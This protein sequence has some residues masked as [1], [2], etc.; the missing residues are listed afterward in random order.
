MI[1]YWASRELGGSCERFFAENGEEAIDKLREVRPDV[2]LLDLEMP[3]MN[4]LEVVM[5]M[6]GEGIGADCRII[7]VSAGAQDRDVTALNALGVTDVVIK[8]EHLRANLRSALGELA[9][10]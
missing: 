6:R 5:C 3:I 10:S 8:D 2:M 4:G 7:A 1:A 9:D